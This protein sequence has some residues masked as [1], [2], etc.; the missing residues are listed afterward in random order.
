M[1]KLLVIHNSYRNVGGEDIAVNNELSLLDKHFEINKLIFS[2][3]IKSPY[4]QSF[5]FLINKNLSDRKMV[6]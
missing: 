5:Y 1:K 6:I 3:Q 4:K 2:N